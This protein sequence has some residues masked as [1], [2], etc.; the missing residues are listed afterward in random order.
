MPYV[1][2][3]GSIP[4]TSEGPAF[5]WGTAVWRNRHVAQGSRYVGSWYDMRRFT[6]KGVMTGGRVST[7]QF[8]GSIILI[9]GGVGT[10]AGETGSIVSNRV[11]AAGMY[12]TVQINA[13][14]GYLKPH[15]YIGGTAGVKGT[16]T[17]SIMG[18]S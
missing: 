1:D 4:T 8:I 5:F 16:L 17:L 6:M 3:Q 7:G 11:A 12:G 18:Q 2:R 13:P 10:T 14:L 15:I 9:A